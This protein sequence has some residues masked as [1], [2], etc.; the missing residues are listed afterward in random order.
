VVRTACAPACDSRADFYTS[1]WE[2]LS[3]DSLLTLPVSADFIAVPDTVQSYAVRDALAE[4][5]LSLIKMT[6]SPDEPTLTA[7]FAT[8]DY[9]N[10]DVAD[11]LR[12]YVHSDITYRWNGSRFAR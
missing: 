8:L 5:S 11:K 2:P 3:A 4:A 6:L 12:P 1:Q 7:S 10:P 9:L